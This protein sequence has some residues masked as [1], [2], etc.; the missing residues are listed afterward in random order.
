[1]DENSEN[2][3]R[4]ERE[5]WNLL[6]HDGGG[7]IEALRAIKLR[8]DRRGRMKQL[9]C[10]AIRESS[11]GTFAGKIYCFGGKTYVPIEKFAFY[12]ILFQL[13]SERIQVPAADLVHMTDIYQDCSNVVFSK[14][15]VLSN[16]VMIFHNGVLDVEKGK[17]YR[18]FDSRFVH[19][20][21]VDYDYEKGVKT[22]LWQ[23]FLDQVLPDKYWQDALQMFLGATFVDRRKVKIEHIVILL[24]RGANG[25]SVIQQAVCG[26]L[27]ADYVSTMEVGRL[28]SRSTDG[29][30]AVAD[31]N[32]RRLN[33]CTEMEETDFLR[34]SARLKAIVSGEAVTARQL[35]G[36]PFK[37]TNIPL[38]MANA[39]HLPFFNTKD[40][41]MM[42]R[43]YVIP[44]NVTIHEEEQD[45]ELSDKLV[46]EYPGILNWILEG[47]EKFIQNGYRLPRDT[48]LEK[49]VEE[50]AIEFNSVNRFMSMNK[51]QP[52]PE[53]QYL[54]P[55]VWRTLNDLYN[56]YER[57]CKHNFITDIQ[58]KIPFRNMLINLE[59]H[60]ERKS[61]GMSF[62]LYGNAKSRI[63]KM[64]ERMRKLDKDDPKLTWI[65]SVG[66]ASSISQL[67][68]YTSV[69]R[70]VLLRLKADGYINECIRMYEGKTLYNVTAIIEVLRRMRIIATDEEK[71]FDKKMADEM[72]KERNRFNARMKA[73]DWPYRKYDTDFEHLDDGIIVVPDETTD[74]ECMEMARA[75]GYETGSL[76]G[77]G[78]TILK[79]RNKNEQQTES[80]EDEVDADQQLPALS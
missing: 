50:Q 37:A 75:A 26:V 63:K 29:D 32:G 15:I 60:Y 14:H 33:Y 61:R 35:Y 39:N 9:L 55:I 62:A 1:M 77:Q 3:K 24:G 34:K 49:V 8:E 19:F 22:Y 65:D 2:L 12:N 36:V 38:L 28:C 53:G 41:A 71:E 68:K 21:S 78:F 66:Y 67:M 54:E 6:L 11:L 5:I 46:D 56:E 27:G 74:V 48:S 7:E 23:K 64:K 52:H 73:R 59:Y 42:R 20:W 4:L 10:R 76:Y 70:H 31:V 16:G 69:S 30:M 80:E 79:E 58:R 17:F 25:K 45:R 44:F 40:E 72:H 13:C 43:I 51:Y 57:W 47:R 18:T